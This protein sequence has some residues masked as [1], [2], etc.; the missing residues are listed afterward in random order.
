EAVHAD[1]HQLARRLRLLD[2]VRASRDGLLEKAELEGARRAAEGV[3]L[4]DE[5]A[6]TRLDR[7]GQALDVVTAAERVDHPGDAA[8]V[9]DH[10]LCAERQG[11]RLLRRER[12]RLV[13][14]VGAQR[15]S[16][17]Q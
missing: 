17:A 5:L 2:L 7:V 6:R 3:D 11:R 4:G 13:V 16:A 14:A 12:Q 1:Y 10:L 8:L 9:P 15:L